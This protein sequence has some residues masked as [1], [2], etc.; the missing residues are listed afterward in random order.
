[1]NS[2]PTPPYISHRLLS[3]TGLVVILAI[4]L[5]VSATP[6]AWALEIKRMQLSNGAVL[7]VSEQH[8][9]PMVTAAIAFDAG[10]RR[11]PTGKEG[12]AAL[13]AESM[14]EGT[15]SLS[16][17]KF[18]E[19]MDFMGSSVGIGASRDFSTATFT[20]LTKYRDVTLHM[21]AQLLQEPGLRDADIMRK[22]AEQVAAIKAAE[23]E[24]S[25]T[26]NVAFT[27]TLFGN[28]PYGHPASGTSEAVSKLTPGDVREFYQQH[29]KLGGAIIAVAG[30][31]TAEEI[32]GALEK[33]L[34]GLQGSVAP[35]TA[36]AAPVV[37]AGIHVQVIDRNVAQ[38]NM[39]LGA[40]GISRSDPDY[41]KLQ[42]MNYILGGGGFAS[43]LMKVVRS[44]AGLAYSIGSVFQAGKFPGAFVVVL[45]TKNAS[46]NE[47]LKLILEQLRD[48]QQ[49]P[50]SSTELADAKRYL[51]GTFPLKLDRQSEIV[52]F[53]LETEIYQLGLDYAD[54]Y[55]KI[56]NA[57][58]A[59]DVQAVAQK[60]LHP[61]AL[62]LVAVANQAEAKIAVASDEPHKQAS[63]TSH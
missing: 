9:L 49:K 40:G 41:Y 21:L 14:T 23:E 53:M 32:K 18:N 52:S 36:P 2:M 50:V 7:L 59:A 37:P 1:M 20:A 48:I 12:L 57:I 60:Y 56:I 47:A 27:K 55:P 44:K 16:A 25:Y 11:D 3:L 30:D 8:Q 35:Q 42:V 45:E 13:T 26:A 4:C 54:R 39:F 15:K 24:P 62:D 28:G 5:L 58:S 29:Y 31:V 46:A 34:S 10:S 17:E 38:A 22:Q 19:Q 61:D 33:E 6:S 51:I 43:H 63:A